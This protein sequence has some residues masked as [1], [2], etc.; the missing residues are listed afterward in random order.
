[1]TVDISARVVYQTC[2]CVFTA[3]ALQGRNQV[4]DG[5]YMMFCCYA[6][7]HSVPFIRDYRDPDC[8]GYQSPAVP[9]PPEA[10]SEQEACRLTGQTPASCVSV[11]AMMPITCCSFNKFTGAIV[12]STVLLTAGGRSMGRQRSERRG[13][14]G[15]RNAK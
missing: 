12:D 13:A 2:W 15:N 10:L 9:I 11:R 14:P 1:M 8:R 4:L 6:G 5:L 3:T 7:H